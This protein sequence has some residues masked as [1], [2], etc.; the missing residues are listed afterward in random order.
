MRSLPALGFHSSPSFGLLFTRLEIKAAFDRAV[1]ALSDSKETK[2]QACSPMES[3]KGCKVW[4]GQ[5]GKY[6]S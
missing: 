4:N 5:L 3:Q 2:R 6:S 1:L